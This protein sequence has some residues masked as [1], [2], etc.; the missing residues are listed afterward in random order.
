MSI[1][2]KKPIGILTFS[3]WHGTPNLGSSRI[4]AEWLVKYWKEAEL[5]QQGAQYDVII[6]QKAYWP[7]YCKE[8]KGIKILDL[9]DPDWLGGVPVKE[10][11]C[12]CDAVVTA[13]E[14]LAMEIRKITDIPVV[15]IPDR[16][17]LE[18]HSEQKSHRGIAK[19]VC[20]FGYSHNSVLL[21]MV[22]PS[23]EKN[24]LYL[25]VISDGRP[26]YKKAHKN[27]KYDWENP[28]FDFNREVTKCDFVIMPP[29]NRSKGR[30]KSNN[31]TI[32]SWALGMPVASNDK[33]VMRFMDPLEREKEKEL[34]LKEVKENWD[35]RTSVKEYQDLIKKLKDGHKRR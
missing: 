2:N 22:I 17:D 7:E 3:Q 19:W 18:F 14:E 15:C 32:T 16:V 20:W 4:R 12:E 27:V 1:H 24:K 9:C 28:L 6:F 30:F 35:V 29:D 10:M 33:D 13:T 26:P 21:D 34:R 8:F 31:K 5:F 23:L 11:I 25:K